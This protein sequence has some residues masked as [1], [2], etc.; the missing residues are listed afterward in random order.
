MTE[1]QKQL[2]K[3]GAKLNPDLKN[4][5]DRVIVPGMVRKYLAQEPK[6]DVLNFKNVAHSLPD[7]PSA[8]VGQ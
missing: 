1:R 6:A 3:L 8:E 5:I 4:W 7:E 2:D